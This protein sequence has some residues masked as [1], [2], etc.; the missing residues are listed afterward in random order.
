MSKLT[1][2]CCLVGFLVALTV[3]LGFQSS[4][5]M[6]IPE[7][8][9]SRIELDDGTSLRC[10]VITWYTNLTSS[11]DWAPPVATEDVRATDPEAQ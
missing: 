5:V 11:C 7:I 8:T 4:K 2:I 10:A 3:S 9:V 1:A 6:P